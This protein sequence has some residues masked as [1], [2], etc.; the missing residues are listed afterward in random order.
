M[1]NLVY[2]TENL[3][4]KIE[5]IRPT[6]NKFMNWQNYEKDLLKDLGVIGHDI[7]NKFRTLNGIANF[8]KNRKLGFNTL[9]MDLVMGEE[10]FL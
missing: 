9:M 8:S 5:K 3:K 7:I 2:S 6:N 10:S 4:I 1:N